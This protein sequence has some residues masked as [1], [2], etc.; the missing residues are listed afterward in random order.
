MDVNSQTLDIRDAA[1]GVEALRAANARRTPLAVAGAGSKKQLGRHA[2]Q[3]QTISTKALTGVTLY[4]PDE[5]VL[6]ARAGTPLREIE[7]L[8]DANNQQLA[9]EPVDYAQ[10]FGGATRSATIGG[11]VAVNASGP[12]RVK[13]GAAR[14]HLL[15][16]HCVTGRGEIVKSGGRVMKNVTGYDLSK[17]VCGSFGTLAL[18]TEVTLK[19]LPKAETEQTLLVVGLDEEKSLAQLRRASGTPNEVSSFAMLPAGAGPLQIDANVAAVRVEG[20]EISVATRCEAL[21][22]EL[23][24]SGAQFEILQPSESAAFW[25]SLRDAAPIAAHSGQIWRISVAPTDGFMVVEALRRAGAPIIAHYYDWVGGL[26]WI[27]LEPAPDAHASAVRGAVDARG[28]HATLIRASEDTRARVDVFHP[29]PAPL[30]A[31]TRRVKDSFD[32][33]HVL[34]RGRMRAEF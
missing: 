12:R 10:L 32:P 9:F 2:P 31:L 19:I 23:R 7:D 25:K 26:V 15:G 27:C 22:A 5:L 18:L 28:G 8:L 4:E 3:S 29:Q 11:V 21:M 17:L 24:D 1:D 13:A 14:D 33:A 16:F 34:E 20:P 6:S 30:A